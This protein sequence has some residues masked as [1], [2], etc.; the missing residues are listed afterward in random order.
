[1]YKYIRLPQNFFYFYLKVALLLIECPFV[2]VCPAEVE[3]TNRGEILSKNLWSVNSSMK[4]SLVLVTLHVLNVF[5]MTLNTSESS[6]SVTN[7]QKHF[8]QHINMNVM[9][10]SRDKL[11]NN[12]WKLET[13]THEQCLKLCNNMASA[14]S[15]QIS[16]N[17]LMQSTNK[18]I[19]QKKLALQNVD[20]ACL[21]IHFDYK[22]NNTQ[23]YI[24]SS[25][26]QVHSIDR[27]TKL[28]KKMIIKKKGEVYVYQE[29]G[30]MEDKLCMDFI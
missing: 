29:I 5:A 28:K 23:M 2:S 14:S 24:H 12:M 16:N 17:E 30:R 18:I 11:L 3:G 22:T 7:K 6:T 9:A 13:L 8:N 1:I 10:T 15:L 25:D 21:H 26:I 20:N 27:K 19:L 4:V